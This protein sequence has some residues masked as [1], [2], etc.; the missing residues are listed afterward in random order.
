MSQYITWDYVGTKLGAAK[1]NALC[2]TSTATLSLIISEASAI[3]ESAL[4]SAGHSTVPTSGA[5][6]D[7]V[8]RAVFGQLLPE[9]YGRKGLDV[10]DNYLKAIE[11]SEKIVSGEWPIPN[12]DPTARDA[13][14]GVKFS[15]SST[16][17]EGDKPQIWS[18][19]RDEY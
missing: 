17:V 14:G 9:L 12:T 4:Q 1:R 19:L 3:V 8:K 11:F 5:A 18:N 6:G 10:P 15:G 7:M 16:T 2:D 13:V